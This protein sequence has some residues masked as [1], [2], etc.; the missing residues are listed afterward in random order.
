MGRKRQN[1]VRE[2]FYLDIQRDV[3][4]CK[5]CGVE[6]KGSYV[7]NLKRHLIQN[8]Y[9]SY[10]EEVERMD[11][12]NNQVREKKRKISI[13]LSTEDV[14]NACVDLVTKE[15]Q[16]FALLDC[17]AFRVLTNQIFNGLHMPVINS[18]CIMNYVSEKYEHVKNAITNKCK[19]QMIS[20]K[21][22][23]ATR[24]D[25]S[26]LGINVQIIL[27]DK[28]E[29]YTLAMKE[30]TDKA[31]GEMLKNVLENVLSDFQ[32]KKKQI[33][34][35]TTDNG[36]NMLKA[37]ETFSSKDPNE[38]D[39]NEDFDDTDDSL[40]EDMFDAPDQI[41]SIKCAAHTL[42]LAIKDFFSQISNGIISSAREL[43]K[44]LRTPSLRYAFHSV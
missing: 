41:I 40:S 27:H 37:V 13:K 1:N 24:L 16:P 21:M 20:L 4:L 33:Y 9:E 7:C 14:T 34:C 15:S 36:R 35:I 17:E 19:N 31:T 38:P 10:I 6:F 22:D 23:T 25:R 3:S 11:E 28:I 12:I 29:I 43:V 18:K 2:F 39:E 42:Q 5:I 26:V 32:I 8:H 30:L 44:T